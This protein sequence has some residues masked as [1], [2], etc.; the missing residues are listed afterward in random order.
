MVYEALQNIPWQHGAF[1][2]LVAV[3]I[4]ALIG[5]RQLVAAIVHLLDNRT[6]HVR[7]AL[8]EAARLKAEAEAMLADAR[9]RQQE[10]TEDARRIL[11]AA[12]AEAKRVAA[13]LA[14]DA[15]ANA[16]RRERMAMERIA[17]AEASAIRDVRAV[18]VDIATQA[19]SALLRDG[20]SAE[21][22]GSRVD[23][24]IAGLPAAL[25]QRIS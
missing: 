4:F 10:A 9:A 3:V 17:A 2:V 15:E 22:D 12:Q 19:A 5:G 14:A 23:A 24:A 6:R 13:E 11:A 8:D 1:W 16:K 21:Q 20:F 25:R 7:A 18:A